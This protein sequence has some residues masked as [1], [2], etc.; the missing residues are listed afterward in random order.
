MI[1]PTAMIEE[2][3]SLEHRLHNAI[4]RNATYTEQ[5]LD[6][7]QRIAELEA[8]LEQAKKTLSYIL[9]LET[10]GTNFWIDWAEMVAELKATNPEYFVKKGEK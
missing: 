5:I 3:K 1:D 8:K 10:N 6:L 7:Q 2:I 9:N 4:H